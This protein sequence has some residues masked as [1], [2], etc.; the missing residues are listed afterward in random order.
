MDFKSSTS[1]IPKSPIEGRPSYTRKGIKKNPTLSLFFLVSFALFVTVVLIAT[2]L[3][4]YN[5]TLERGIESKEQQL[6]QARASFEP[7]I[8]EELVRLDRRLNV[9]RSIVYNHNSISL[10][11]AFLED[12]TVQSLQF[13]DFEYTA[14]AERPQI[15]LKGRSINFNNLA[16]QAEIL[17]NEHRILNPVFSN[18]N[19]DEAGGVEFE[20]SA[21]LDRNMVAYSNRVAGEEMQA[22]IQEL[23][24]TDDDSDQDTD[25]NED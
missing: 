8:I 7:A 23:N 21:E 19:L 17:N 6:T 1:F 2:G 25:V 22:E 4:V 20:V 16:Q 9:A 13:S 14:S 10:F 18:L 12:Q 24:G 5:I 11:F 15:K 3:F